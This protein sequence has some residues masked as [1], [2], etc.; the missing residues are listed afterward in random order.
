MKNDALELLKEN[1]KKLK[2]FGDNWLI[3]NRLLLKGW[4]CLE[5]SFLSLV[6]PETHFTEQNSLVDGGVWHFPGPEKQRRKEI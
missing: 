3:K 6:S 4:C 2:P 5:K 1:V